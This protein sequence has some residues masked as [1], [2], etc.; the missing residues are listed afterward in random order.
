MRAYAVLLAV[1]L[2][3]GLA[4]ANMAP[5]EDTGKT[6]RL[7]SSEDIQLKSEEV[8]IVPGRGPFLMEPEEINSDF[9]LH[10]GMR[11][12]Y[13]VD[14][15]C[16]FVLHN[17]AKKAVKIQVGFPLAEANQF[18]GGPPELNA[19]D[20]T[21]FVLRH[22]FIVRDTDQT[23]HVRY[24]AHDEKKK[25]LAIFLWDMTFQADETRELNVAYEMPAFVAP[26]TANID[27][28]PHSMEKE[29][30]AKNYWIVEGGLGEWF[31]Y[32]TETGRSWA[33]PIEHAKFQVYVGGFERFL[34]DRSE[35]TSKPNRPPEKG[36]TYGTWGLIHREV[37]PAGWKEDRGV[38]TWEFQDYRPEKPIAV[39]YL[40]TV[41]PRMRDAVP[42]FI[43]FVLGEK[44]RP[45]DI[46]DLREIYLAWWGIV[47]KSEPVRQF[48]S[49]QCWY[50]PKDGMTVDKLTPEQ[51]AI[52][53]ELERR[54]VAAKTG[55]DK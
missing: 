29:A 17:R 46:A 3:P 21:D 22:R 40:I 37:S 24:V 48:V 52:A 27:G 36:V 9:W 43:R 6:I 28:K 50:S 5:F 47:P 45:E 20:V 25:L 23:Y 53:A 33:G 34:P 26:G 35:T 1:A 16:K 7:V 12:C 55:K 2:A 42:S 39:N 10:G 4:G 11:G 51:K 13:L 32:V 19:D 14:Y 30:G 8:K 38:L 31:W 54:A 18:W 15:R 41:F 49:Q 44:P